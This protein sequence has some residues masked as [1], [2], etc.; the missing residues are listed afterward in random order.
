MNNGRLQITFFITSEPF[1]R[2]QRYSLQAVRPNAHRNAIELWT[3][4]SFVATLLATVIQISLVAC[5]RIGRKLCCWNLLNEKLIIYIKSW[6]IRPVKPRRNKWAAWQW[7]EIANKYHLIRDNY[8]PKRLNSHS[9]R[10]NLSSLTRLFDVIVDF[11]RQIVWFIP[12]QRQLCMTTA[13]DKCA[14]LT[15]CADLTAI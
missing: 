12:H 6:Q 14:M 8:P 10:I 11:I 15:L 3:L 5:V 1:V 2:A 9:N 4:L 13:S 7:N